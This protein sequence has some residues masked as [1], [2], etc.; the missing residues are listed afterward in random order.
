MN[1]VEEGGEVVQDDVKPDV[2][3][4]LIVNDD[5]DVQ[6]VVDLLVAVLVVADGACDHQ[7]LA[8]PPARRVDPRPDLG[9]VGGGQDETLRAQDGDLGHA[10]GGK[11]LDIVLKQLL[12]GLPTRS[13]LL[14]ADLEGLGEIL[15]LVLDH[16]HQQ[17]LVMFVGE[18]EHSQGES[19]QG[20]DHQRKLGPD[21][22]IPHDARH[23]N[24]S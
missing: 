4:L 15:R 7:R 22:Q 8:R 9:L 10:P 13:E 11:T 24:G 14:H 6:V 21:P 3:L 16:V 23:V 1:G 17:L 2:P 12:V 5:G 19:H 18:E 20:Q